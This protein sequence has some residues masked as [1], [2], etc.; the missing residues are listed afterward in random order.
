MLDKRYLTFYHLSRNLSFTA[1]AAELFITQPAVSQ[2][3]KSL[4]AELKLQ[5]VTRQHGRIQLTDAGQSLQ[6]YVRLIM[7][8]NQHFLAALQQSGRP[9]K[10][11]LGCTRSLSHTLLPPLLKVLS[12]QYDQLTVKLTNTEE[13]LAGLRAGTIDLSLIEGNFDTT[14]FDAFFLRNSPFI[15]VTGQRRLSQ[16]PQFDWDQLHQET[17]LV[18]EAGSGSREILTSFLATQNQHLNQFPKQIE[19]PDPETI[20]QVLRSGVGFSFLYRDL[21]ATELDQQ[22]LWPLT[23]PGF[24]ISHPLNLVFPKNSF[25]KAEYREYANLLQKRV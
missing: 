3:I 14:E 16:A 15:A 23:F 10:L 22:R 17:L 20:I 12:Q 1:T 19:L 13:N 9:T 7:T 24:H 5:L 6:R 4:E 18:R 2:Q 21:V 11:T 8:E 25:F